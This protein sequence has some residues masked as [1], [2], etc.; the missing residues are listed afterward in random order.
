MTGNRLAFIDWLKCLGMVL[1]VLG[2]TGAQNYVDPT[3]PFNFKQLGVAFFVFV[4]GFSLARERRPT[5]LVLYHRLFDIWLFGWLGALV[6]S[7]ISWLTI[8]DLN[9][10]NYLP[11][12][13][14]ANVLFNHFP[15]NP[16]TWYIGT[17]FHLLLLWDCVLRPIRVRWWMVAAS[18]VAEILIRAALM[19]AAGGFVAYMLLTNWTTL[20]LLGMWIGQQTDVRPSAAAG[21]I[22]AAALAVLAI[23]WPLTVTRIGLTDGFPFAR[24]NLATPALSLLATSAAVTG[25]YLACTLLAHRMAL[26]LPESSVVRFFADNTLI[27]FIAHMPLIYAVTPGLYPLVPAGPLGLVRMLTNLALFFVLPALCSALIRRLV[28]PK[29]LRDWLLNR[30]TAAW[31]GAAVSKSAA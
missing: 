11:L 6:L 22:A 13:L 31:C 5:P 29:L 3:P 15:A 26:Q 24:L 16:T 9:E 30:L 28:Q 19:H 14:G 12:A 4:M 21:A 8:R 20:L 23:A 18:A 2:H 7:A 10:S 1:I 17:Y 25:L 27:V